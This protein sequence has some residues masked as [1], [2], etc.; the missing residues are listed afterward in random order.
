[1]MKKKVGVS[2]KTKKAVGVKKKTVGMKKG[3]K[4]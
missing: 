4:C 1:M 3:K 2:M